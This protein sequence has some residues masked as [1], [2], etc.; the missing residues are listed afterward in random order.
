[1][2]LTG[3]VKGMDMLTRMVRVQHALRRNAKDSD[4]AALAEALE[5]VLKQM[6]LEAF[7]E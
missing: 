5:G 7:M 4:E 1:M 2:G 3:I 6:G